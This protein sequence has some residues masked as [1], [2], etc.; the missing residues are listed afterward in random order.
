LYFGLKFAVQ[1]NLFFLKDNIYVGK[2]RCVSFLNLVMPQPHPCHESMD[3]IL[4]NNTV[5]ILALQKQ[6]YCISGFFKVF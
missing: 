3:S 5:S 4:V 2:G 1:F 6:I